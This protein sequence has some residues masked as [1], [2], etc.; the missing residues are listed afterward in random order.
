MKRKLLNTYEAAASAGVRRPTLQFWIKT[1][2]ISAP[3][4]RLRGGRAVRLWTG[5][6]IEWIRKLKGTLKPGPKSRV[7]KEA[8]GKARSLK[9]SR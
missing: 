8:S 4:V 2:R 1:R 9:C 3:R 5:A 6:Q 7:A